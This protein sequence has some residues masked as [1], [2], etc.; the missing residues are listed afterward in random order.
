MHADCTTPPA[1]QLVEPALPLAHSLNTDAPGHWEARKAALEALR[2]RYAAEGYSI[3]TAAEMAIHN[4]DG[5]LEARARLDATR[6]AVRRL[7]LLMIADPGRARRAGALL[8]EGYSPAAAL[9]AIALS[10]GL[11]ND[12]PARYLAA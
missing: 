4:L 12:N 5:Q 2:D 11:M 3:G 8:A 10:D 7:G 6:S 1:R 9:R